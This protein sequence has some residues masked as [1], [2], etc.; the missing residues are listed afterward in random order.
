MFRAWGRVG[1]TIGGTKTED[2]GQDI[3]DCQDKFKELFN[4]KC[5]N[6]WEDYIQGNFKKAPTGMDVLEMDTEEHKVN[7]IISW[8]IF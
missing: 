6:T 4:E 5:F 3:E 2:Y 1:T 8:G 7:L